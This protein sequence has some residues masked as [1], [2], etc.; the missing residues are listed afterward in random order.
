MRNVAKIEYDLR[1]RL[2]TYFDDKNKRITSRVINNPK[3]SFADAVALLEVGL[4]DDSSAYM[5]DVL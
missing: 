5:E 2:V 1:K 4:P 3:L